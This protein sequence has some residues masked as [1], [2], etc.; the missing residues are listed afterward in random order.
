MINKK[1]KNK[2]TVWFVLCRLFNVRWSLLF[3]LLF[4]QTSIFN[5]DRFLS[6]F[7]G[8]GQVVANFRWQFKIKDFILWQKQIF[9]NKYLLICILNKHLLRYFKITKP[10]RIFIKLKILSINYDMTIKQITLVFN[11]IFQ[12]CSFQCSFLFQRST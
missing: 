5:H 9:T 1:I 12:F 2:K 10:F 7:G 3:L 4:S 8:G 6:F 11:L